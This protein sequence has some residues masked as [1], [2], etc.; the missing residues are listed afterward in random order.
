MGQLTISPEEAS[1]I[2]IHPLLIYVHEEERINEHQAMD[3]K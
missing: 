3:H 1:V 2:G